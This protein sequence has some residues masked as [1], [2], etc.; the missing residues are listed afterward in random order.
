M[1]D[2]RSTLLITLS[3]NDRPGVTRRLFSTLA[4]YP[5]TVLDVEQLV[6][7]GRL[8]L[9][10]L[11]E[12]TGDEA[13]VSATRTAVRHAA[14]DLDMDVETVP[15]AAE[16]DERRRN[17]IHITMMGNPLTP[18]A[19][20]NVAAEIA[21]RGGNIDRI[22]RIASY[23]V[24]A[25][26]FEGS[27]VSVE[28][29]RR[30]LAAAAAA[31]GAD[32]AV[33]EAGLDRRGQYLVVMDVDSTFIQD[34]VIDLLADEAGVRA[35]VAAVTERA[36]AGELDFEASLR[37]RAALLKG[38]PVSVIDRVRGRITLTPGARTL[39]R[40]L[41]RLGYRVALV[42][43][44]FSEVIAPLAAELGVS[45]VRA[46]TLEVKD[47]VLT[48]HV[49]GTVIDR[50]GKRTAMEEIAREHGIPAR[51]TIA[52]GDGANDI[53]MLEAA[54]LGIAFNAKAAA[55]A[56]ADTALNV[57]YLDSVL[58][59]LGITREEI[60]SADAREGLWTTSRQQ[61]DVDV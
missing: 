52:I 56:A 53:D 54:G 2:N 21:D 45:D 6:V 11:V 10:V 3:G 24:T 47:G 33:Q 19:V 49:V 51:R 7:R 58:Y 46:N 41:N 5:I 26:V 29:L 40:T 28:E 14:A 17:R 18:I 15:G 38:L 31:H 60:E 44:G 35:E 30:P 23:P 32:I 43:G 12:I 39:C 4:D 9:A 48:G 37:A 16:D 57:P 61:R 1:D 36:M 20:A 59:L 55:R 27:G 22:R 25:I 8:V 50:L 34:E 13:A 42:S